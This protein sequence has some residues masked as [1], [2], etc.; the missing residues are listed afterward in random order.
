MKISPI[1]PNRINFN[2]T[3]KELYHPFREDIATDCYGDGI[4]INKIEQKIRKHSKDTFVK[5]MDDSSYDIRN[6]RALFS[7]EMER[8]EDEDGIFINP[9]SKTIFLNFPKN[10]SEFAGFIAELAHEMTHAFQQ[11]ADDRL[12]IKELVE[13]YCGNSDKEKVLNTL[14]IMDDVFIGLEYN[15][16]AAYEREPDL[17]GFTELVLASML[18]DNHEKINYNMLLDYCILRAR[19]EEE[20]YL[21]MYDFAHSPNIEY[22]A[23]MYDAMASL[24]HEIAKEYRGNK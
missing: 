12:S 23:G 21:N 24:L 3:M 14:K 10:I 1:L 20:A 6:P 15:F 19:N 5:T 13:M 11:E 2:K 8:F 22:K 17:K 9:V 18:I 16:D 4:L 7:M